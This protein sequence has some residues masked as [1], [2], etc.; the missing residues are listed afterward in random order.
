MSYL[1]ILHFYLYI[2][3]LL[4]AF[5][6]MSSDQST[7]V[8]TMEEI[9]PSVS[10]YTEGNK[11]FFILRKT[12]LYARTY[13]KIFLHPIAIYIN[14]L[15]INNLRHNRTRI[16]LLS[17]LLFFNSFLFILKR[18][19]KMSLNFVSIF[20]YRL[21]FFFFEVLKKINFLEKFPLMLK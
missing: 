2:Y 20:K 8:H 6:G 9:Q 4:S 19:R 11:F 14:E 1:I 13:I 3:I 15:V 10:V 16:E 18:K 21:S 7:C 12:L 17:F 5:F